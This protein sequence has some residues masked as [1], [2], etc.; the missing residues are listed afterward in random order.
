MIVTMEWLGRYLAIKEEI[1][2]IETRL[3]AI[4]GLKSLRLSDNPSHTSNNEGIDSL[5]IRR[6]D[7]YR[8]YLEKLAE[9]REV[10]YEIVVFLEGVKDPT[11]RNIIRL[12]YIDGLTWREVGNCLGLDHSACYRRVEEVLSGSPHNNREM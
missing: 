2:V 10:V 3:D 7:L 8:K 4:D 12:K 9:A 5:L 1:E 11:T 6:G